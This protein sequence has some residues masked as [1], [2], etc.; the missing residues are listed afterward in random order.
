MF[1]VVFARSSQAELRNSK[2]EN[3]ALRAGQ[4]GLAAAKQNAEA[5]L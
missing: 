3:E 2:L 5:A 1:H 4:A